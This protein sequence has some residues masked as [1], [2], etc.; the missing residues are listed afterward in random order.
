MDLFKISDPQLRK[1][2]ALT[3]A[4]TNP[5]AFNS[6]HLGGHL[7]AFELDEA[8]LLEVIRL[9]IINC[10]YN[11]AVN[12]KLVK[13]LDTRIELFK[14]AV[15][16]DPM[17][18][19]VLQGF[20]IPPK[21]QKELCA[22]GIS[23]H[24]LVLRFIFE[25]HFQKAPKEKSIEDMMFENAPPMLK[26][27]LLQQ[28]AVQ[29]QFRRQEQ[30]RSQ[31]SKTDILEL[32]P[33]ALKKSPRE[34]FH[35]LFEYRLE[36]GLHDFIIESLIKTLISNPEVIIEIIAEFE[37]KTDREALIN[38][39]PNIPVILSFNKGADVSV[40]HSL[41]QKMPPCMRSFINYL[42]NKLNNLSNNNL[43]KRRLIEWCYVLSWAIETN[44]ID[45]NC[46]EKICENKIFEKLSIPDPE[47]RGN[48]CLKLGNAE[49][50]KNAEIWTFYS[51]INRSTKNFELISL[52]LS[53]FAATLTRRSHSNP[54]LLIG[55][56]LALTELFEAV[57]KNS[58]Y[59]KDGKFQKIF[60][61]IFFN[62]FSEV[63]SLKL[64]SLL[65]TIFQKKEDSE[66]T[67]ASNQRKKSNP[68][69]HKEVLLRN[70]SSLQILAAYSELKKL[71][72]LEDISQL[73][74]LALATA[75]TYLHLDPDF[76]DFEKKYDQTFNSCRM[77][78]ALPVY[79]A[80]LRDE[81]PVEEYRKVTPLL[82]KF[83]RSV[84]DGKFEEERYQIDEKQHP[85]MHLLASKYPELFAK[86]KQNQSH[87]ISHLATPAAFFRCEF[88][89]M[90]LKADDY[91]LLYQQLVEGKEI[92]S[93]ENSL[94][95]KF[96]ELCLKLIREGHSETI[97]SDLLA[98]A[99]TPEEKN[100]CERL[101]KFND[102][103]KAS[104][105]IKVEKTD[106]PY[107]LMLCGTEVPSCQNVRGRA[108]NNICLIAYITDPKNQLLAI[109]DESIHARRIVRIGFNENE[110]P[111]ILIEELYEGRL[112]ILHDI[113]LHEMSY[114]LAKELNLP[115]VE[116]T[117]ADNLEHYPIYFLSSSAPYDYFDSAH[118]KL[119]GKVTIEKVRFL[120]N[121]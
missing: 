74:Q 20:D 26:A 14:L 45:K 92:G 69:A 108:F 25:L 115:L 41:E 114:Q 37:S 10:P 12:S 73:P 6:S 83:V 58:K 65:I 64:I 39:H 52:S 96:E 16:Q 75:K 15:T 80:K 116:A 40:L 55:E 54:T 19:K 81:L 76:K 63:N 70:L 7:T 18:I 29:E 102:Q 97:I 79:A 4:E 85:H 91:P 82:A 90:R 101:K 44:V 50:S 27:I 1:K 66:S 67:L 117:S 13:N 112:S 22:F 49:M 28:R 86:W 104:E 48:F 113:V 9:S 21:M 77:P 78:M 31:L 38:F 34:T 3:I 24:F 94:G 118:G 107:H 61:S 88:Y 68:Q 105:N 35:L 72:Q 33:L 60:T 87:P 23:K 100:V 43:L 8:S 95:N 57:R 111:I 93:S 56:V 42:V 106:N 109:T 121:P 59:L 17:A 103:L 36:D 98:Y 120:Y 47:I 51:R 89:R 62:D 2:F 46:L 30:K 119:S 5:Q 110:S 32:I 99:S 11:F 71:E 53:Y 84:L